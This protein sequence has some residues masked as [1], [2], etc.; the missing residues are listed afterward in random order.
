[1][2]LLGGARSGE[3]RE[4]VGKFCETGGKEFEVYLARFTHCT[5]HRALLLG[6]GVNLEE[7]P[8]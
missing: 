4:V 5:V 8:E 6:K 2:K 7:M 3:K 1:M